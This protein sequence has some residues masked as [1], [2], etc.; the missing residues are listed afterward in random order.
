MNL[1]AF[2]ARRGLAMSVRNLAAAAAQAR[3]RRLTAR[4]MKAWQIHGYGNF[5]DLVLNDAV[6]VPPLRRPTDVLVR[7]HAT[8]VNPLDVLMTSGY[9]AT[10]FNGMR[11]LIQG[12][13]FSMEFPLTLGRD[14][15][16]VVVETG[17]AVT[18]FRPGDEVW[19]ATWPHVQGA[20]AEYCVVL[21]DYI[22]TKP[23]NLG[24]VEAASIPYVALTALGALSTFGNVTEKNAGGQRILVVGGSGGV[25][26]IAVQI[27]KSWGAEVTT[28]CSTDAVPLMMSLGADTVVDYKT[29]DADAELRT[30]G[31]YDVVLNCTHQP[32]EVFRPHLKQWAG[33]KYITTSPP[34]VRIVGTYGFLCGG[35]VGAGAY[36]TELLKSLAK[37]STSFWGYFVSSRNALNAV[38]RLVESKQVIPVID[39][40]FEFN[41]L[42]KAYLKVEGGHA[43]GKTVVNVCD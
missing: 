15:S 2:V 34:L 4:C 36:G 26:T 16:G 31:K 32:S 6:R 11:R 40:V 22:T 41:E 8:S 28:T 18:D 39:E 25:G 29:T 14:F 17:P 13:R 43:R 27:L 21:Q 20:H 24:H 5:K 10:L 9:G 19:G 3:P 12:P 35:F 33:A 7:V 37:G 1:Q 30:T 38:K 23:R 42:V